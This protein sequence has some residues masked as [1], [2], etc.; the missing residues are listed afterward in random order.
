MIFSNFLQQLVE[1]VLG[2][3][4]VLKNQTLFIANGVQSHTKHN[5]P[6]SSP[7]NPP[8]SQLFSPWSWVQPSMFSLLL[9]T[10]PSLDQCGPTLVVLLVMQV[11]KIIIHMLFGSLYCTVISRRKP[12]MLFDCVL[13]CSPL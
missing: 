6:T 4:K 7:N 8:Q 10:T 2:Y 11:K 5:L 3:K 1:H 9:S 13:F 12:Q